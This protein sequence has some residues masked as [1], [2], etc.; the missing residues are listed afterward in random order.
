MVS[1]KPDYSYIVQRSYEQTYLLSKLKNIRFK[2]YSDRFIY[3]LYLLDYP[4]NQWKFLRQWYVLRSTK[5]EERSIIYILGWM[6]F[7]DD[8]PKKERITITELLKY[9]NKIMEN[10]ENGEIEDPRYFGYS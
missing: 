7:Y 6:L 8:L 2:S 9:K 1:G 4:E 5:I 3:N 10:L